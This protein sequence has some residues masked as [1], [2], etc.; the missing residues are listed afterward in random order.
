VWLAF[1]CLLLASALPAVKMTF[2]TKTLFMLMFLFAGSSLDASPL[3]D[4]TIRKGNRL[5]H[6]QKYGEAI[7]TYTLTPDLR[8]R[9]NSALAYE[10]L[11]QVSESEALYQG[12]L[13]EP[14][15]SK[16]E[17]SRL[18]FN[19]GN[20]YAKQNKTPAAQQAYIESL[21]L[22]PRYEAARQNLEWLLKIQ[23]NKKQSMPN[24]HKPD[25]QKSRKSEAESDADRAL[26]NFKN[27]EQE[28]I[29]KQLQTVTQGKPRKPNVEKYW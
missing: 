16:W 9:F 27:S 8:G 29:I 2:K 28:N 17:R 5:F 7:Q 22:D 12:L 4:H 15:L 25:K 3:S 20:L 14:A 6:N 26:D 13:S 11:N 10:A 24:G 21:K 18:W 1:V 19:L 23:K